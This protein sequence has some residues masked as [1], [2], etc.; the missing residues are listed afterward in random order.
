MATV[1]E[2]RAILK[3]LVETN[4]QIGYAVGGEADLGLCLFGDHANLICQV[5]EAL[6]QDLTQRGLLYFGDRFG[7]WFLTEAGELEAKRR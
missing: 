3:R 1:K 7:D 2:R 6:V 4:G 5:D